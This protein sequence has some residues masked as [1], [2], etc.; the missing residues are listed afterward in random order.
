MS[1][2]TISNSY[3]K[4]EGGSLIAWQRDVDNVTD[5]SISGTYSGGTP[6]HVEYSWQGGAFSTVSSEVI[7]AGAWSGTLLSLAPGEGTLTVRWSNDHAV[8]AETY[9]FVGDLLLAM[10]DST[11]AINID[12]EVA[13][14]AGPPKSRAIL[15]ASG[16]W[17]DMDTTILS[18]CWPVVANL[19]VAQEGVPVGIIQ[20]SAGGR[21]WGDWI[22]PDGNPAG[23]LLAVIAA[24]HVNRFRAVLL[25]LGTVDAIY[26]IGQSQVTSDMTVVIDML[27]AQLP[28]A[29]P[30]FFISFPGDLST[31]S[32][33]VLDGVRLGMTDAMDGLPAT[34]MG[35]QFSDLDYPDHTHPE[36]D[37]AVLMGTRWFLG[38]SDTLYGTTFGRPPRLVR[39]T[40]TGDT[41]VV[42]FDRAIDDDAITSSVFRVK[43]NGTPLTI[44]SVTKTAARQ[45]T[46]VT[47]TAAVGTVTVDLASGS[48]ASGNAMPVG[49]TETLPDSTTIR[50]PAEFFLDEPITEEPEEPSGRFASVF[51]GV[52][53]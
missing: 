27:T 43:D 21:P 17:A 20:W 1:A 52:V 30:E 31:I 6:T 11:V 51:A 36:P 47:T 10:G 9:L 53:R 40:G 50:R 41:H 8:T 49:L 45:V 23:D 18:G 28:G 3:P 19:I 48:D 32:R 15:A 35:P 29:T 5:V 25:Q 38:I 37:Q 24:S 34:H 46:I 44:S 26:E 22:D 7:G 33:S 39:V 4:H 14:N 16:Y 12:Y 2:I 13:A 42:T